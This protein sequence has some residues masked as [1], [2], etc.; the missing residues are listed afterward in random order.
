MVGDLLGILKNLGF[1]KNNLKLCRGMNIDY[2][3]SFA[4]LVVK[5]IA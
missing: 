3:I 2:L 5:I 4:D 1:N